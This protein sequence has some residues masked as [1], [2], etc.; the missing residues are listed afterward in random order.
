MR[1]ITP[2]RATNR[3]TTKI[4]MTRNVFLCDPDGADTGG[5]ETGSGVGSG[6][7]CMGLLGLI[8]GGVVGMDSGV[9]L[10]NG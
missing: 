3:M 8:G 5:G 10:V 1:A 6:V 7:D 9:V 4:M 2:A